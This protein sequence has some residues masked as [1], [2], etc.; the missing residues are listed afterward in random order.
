M[1]RMFWH[2]RF[3]ISRVTEGKGWQRKVNV[4]STNLAK[5]RG[6]KGGGRGGIRKEKREKEGQG[7]VRE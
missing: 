6:K 5:E 4:P 3:L 7:K 1:I 2:H